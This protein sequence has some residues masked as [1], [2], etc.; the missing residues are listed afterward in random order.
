LHYD[1]DAVLEQVLAHYQMGSLLRLFVDVAPN[2]VA[3]HS[4]H[5]DV[6]SNDPKADCMQY[7]SVIPSASPEGRLSSVNLDSS[8][9]WVGWDGW[10]S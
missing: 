10:A 4:K 5:N 3:S 2:A 6:A 8:C 1:S 9:G 7:V